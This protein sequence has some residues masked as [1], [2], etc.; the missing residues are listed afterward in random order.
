MLILCTSYQRKQPV[1][2]SHLAIGM[3]QFSFSISLLLWKFSLCDI[4][5]LLNSALTNYNMNFGTDLPQFSANFISPSHVMAI[6][7][8]VHIDVRNT[9][10]IIFI[11]LYILLPMFLCT[12]VLH[13]WTAT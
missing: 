8:Y 1:K 12:C 4:P 2:I 5:H 9:Q 3:I 7:M 11:G 6:N 10:K 13:S